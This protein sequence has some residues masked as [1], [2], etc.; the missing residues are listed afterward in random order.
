[1][2]DVVDQNEELMRAYHLTF[3]SA[4]GQ[5]VLLDLMAFGS[6]RQPISSQ[7]DEGKRQVVLRIMEMTLLTP[8][9]IYALYQARI[10]PQARE[11][12]HGHERH[13]KSEPQS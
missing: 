11:G 5:R 1:M 3:H 13:S 10:A 4:S 9:Q 8:E 2:T 12:A 6:F 7:I